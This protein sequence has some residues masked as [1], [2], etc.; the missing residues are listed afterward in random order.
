MY[1]ETKK[2]TTTYNRKT[3]YNYLLERKNS[4]IWDQLIDDIETLEHPSNLNY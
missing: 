4:N 2:T 3:T 1:S